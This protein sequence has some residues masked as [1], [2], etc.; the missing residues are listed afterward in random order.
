MR[1]L[2]LSLRNFATGCLAQG[3]V[4]RGHLTVAVPTRSRLE[5]RTRVY[6]R[7]SALE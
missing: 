4:S 1:I 7:R 3:F 6:G 2:L 5:Y